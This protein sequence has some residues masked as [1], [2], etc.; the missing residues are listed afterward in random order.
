[1]S[2]FGKP[3]RRNEDA[4]L[5]TGRALFVDDVRLPGMLHVAFVR[6]PVAHARI[7]GI[8]SRRFTP[9]AAPFPHRVAWTYRTSKPLLASPAVVAPHVYLT[10]GDGH[11]IALDRHTGQ[12]VWEFYSGWLSSSTPAVAGDSVIFAI[13][14][15]RVVSLNRQTGA[16]LWD[17]HLQSPIVASPVV[18]NG[19]VYIGAAD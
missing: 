4:R 13:R 12:P 5:L 15:G 17:T 18:V 1:M 10:T 8:V 14:P 9:E 3:V 7:R 11:T 16:R 19:T 6:S 2:W